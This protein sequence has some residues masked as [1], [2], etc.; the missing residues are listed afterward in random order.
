MHS[1]DSTEPSDRN[2][3]R[4]SLCCLDRRRGGPSRP[5]A[6]DYCCR[7]LRLPPNRVAA[8]DSPRPAVGDKR[9]C[10]FAL[11]ETCICVS[12]VRVAGR[13]AWPHC[14]GSG[15]ISPRRPRR[16]DG[17]FSDE[18]AA[19]PGKH[20]PPPVV[21]APSLA[22]RGILCGGLTGR[23]AAPALSRTPTPRGAGQALDPS[24]GSPSLASSPRSSGPR[25]TD[26][27]PRQRPLAA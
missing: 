21:T 3:C 23:R 14:P 4:S 26:Q 18:A 17:C 8:S 19:S 1:R 2:A 24:R 10:G 11:I 15:R 27:P 20:G 25:C 6:A 12:E 5:A 16:P 9:D 22:E 7:R 13:L